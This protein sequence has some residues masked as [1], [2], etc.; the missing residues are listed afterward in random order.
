MGVQDLPPTTP[1]D[2]DLRM[3]TFLYPSRYSQSDRLL[4]LAAD[5]FGKEPN[6]VMTVQAIVSWL[7]R[8]IFYLQGITN[9]NTSSVDTLVERAGVCRDFAHLGIAFCR[10]LN[11]PARY[12]SCYATRLDPPD[13]HACFETWIGGRW[14]LWDA[15]RLCSPDSVVLIG[16]GRDAADVSVCTSFGALTLKRQKVTCEDLAPDGGDKMTEDELRTTLV[17]HGADFVARGAIPFA[18]S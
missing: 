2:F 15:T 6:P 11:I 4:R 9:A 3:L 12:F 13:F 1:G 8:N 14:F 17:C 10:A 16:R 7:S 18:T 5:H